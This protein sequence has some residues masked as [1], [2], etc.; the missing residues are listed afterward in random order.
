MDLSE[1]GLAES[2]GYPRLAG[3][4]VD[5]SFRE[6]A[7][8]RGFRHQMQSPPHLGTHRARDY[9][10]LQYE[11]LANERELCSTIMCHLY[12][13]LHIPALTARQLLTQLSESFSML[14]KHDGV[15]D[16]RCIQALTSR[17]NLWHAG[18]RVTVKGIFVC[19]GQFQ[20]STLYA[21]HDVVRVC[22]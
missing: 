13:G 11:P 19:A 22:L 8:K 15:P 16:A 20:N 7:E 9:K 4:Q 5:R 18:I 3:H 12:V 10:V 14:Y 17:L 6:E 2:S 1:L 21:I